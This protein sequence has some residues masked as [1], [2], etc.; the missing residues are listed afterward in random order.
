MKDILLNGKKGR[1]EK[2]LSQEGNNLDYIVFQDSGF[3]Q[4]KRWLTSD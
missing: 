1:E 2:K 3:N 4:E